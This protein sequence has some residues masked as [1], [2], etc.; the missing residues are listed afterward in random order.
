M[1]YTIALALLLLSNSLFAQLNTKKLDSLFYQL[2]KY[3]KAMVSVAISTNGKLEYKNAIGY[4][5]VEKKL[6]SNASALY[7]IGSMSKMF[8]AV[9]IMQLIEENKLSQE[10][11]LSTFYPTIPN[12]EKITIG[13]MLNHNSGIHNFT[14]DSTYETYMEKAQSDDDLLKRFSA[15]TPDFEP[16]NKYN[17]SNT[18]YV[19]L[20]MVIE[21][22]SKKKYADALQ[23]RVCKKIGLKNT[24]IA[25]KINSAEGVAYSYDMESSGWKKSTQ[26]DMSI[27]KGAGAVISTPTDMCLFMEALFGNKLVSE[28]SL[29]EM[30]TITEGYGKGLFQF[31]FGA[32]KAYGH[33]GSI[34]AFESTVG[35]F[36][37]DKK[38]FCIVGNGY[39][40]D[41]N[42]I[43]IGMLSIAYDKPYTIPSL[44]KKVLDDK[45]KK[46]IT[47]KY[48][49]QKINMTIRIFEEGGKVMA[50]AEG[51]SAF[52]LDKVSETEFKFDQ[53][54]IVLV[55]NKNDKGE[56]QNLT[57]KQNGMV[58]PFEK[59][60]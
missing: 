37:E 55:F 46:T 36:P 19:L 44:Q 28:A 15:M 12:A 43:A 47:G 52:A 32:K 22:V 53:A 31:P 2:N 35:Y 51:Q 27:P 40:Y 1:R 50:E 9:M 41:M 59:I 21:K 54:G 5:D 13:Q 33:T 24:R 56:I 4:L 48:K 23:E 14:D 39:D 29:K 38:S 20:S 6:A 16:G 60:E 11:K 49:S 10:T 3:N 45:S 7:H 42:D 18:A 57:L 34:D 58:L 8:T 25:E 26:T 30:T 17:Y